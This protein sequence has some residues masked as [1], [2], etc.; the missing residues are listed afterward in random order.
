MKLLATGFSQYKMP[1]V[2]SLQKLIP[3]L[4]KL[5]QPTLK[6]LIDPKK[7]EVTPLL[8]HYTTVRQIIID[9]YPI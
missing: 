9:V 8:K 4:W 1:R 2:E 7:L 3:M 5:L 6:E